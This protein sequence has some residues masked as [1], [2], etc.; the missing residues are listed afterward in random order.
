MMM[1]MM[2]MMML[3]LVVCSS[4]QHENQKNPLQNSAKQ[5]QAQN[6]NDTILLLPYPHT[7]PLVLFFVNVYPKLCGT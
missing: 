6:T 3:A 1:M 5:T 2:M 4:K 7:S